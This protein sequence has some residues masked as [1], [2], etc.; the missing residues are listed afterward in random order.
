MLGT[1]DGSWVLPLDNYKPKLHFW[2]SERKIREKEIREYRMSLQGE[3][4]IIEKNL[5]ELEKSMLPEP[6]KE[7]DAACKEKITPDRLCVV[8]SK[9]ATAERTLRAAS[10]NLNDISGENSF[11]A[12]Q[13]NFFERLR[14]DVDVSLVALREMI[15]QYKAIYVDEAKEIDNA[16]SKR[17]Q[18]D[19]AYV[20]EMEDA[21][22]K[23]EDEMSTD[24]IMEKIPEDAWE[25]IKAATKQATDVPQKEVTITDIK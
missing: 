7:I 10:V 19:V 23:H 13:G 12:L 11:S 6:K 5:K 20:Q 17:Q 8:L 15:E 18:A 14:R 1:Y 2:Q 25:R 21:R 16:A 9:L 22:R 4:S 3:L 24:I